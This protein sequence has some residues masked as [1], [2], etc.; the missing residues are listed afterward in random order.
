MTE[1]SRWEDFFS[2]LT[3][4]ELEGVALIRVIECTNGCIQ[5]AFRGENPR[6]LPVEQTRKAMKY[7]MGLMKSLD[8]NIGGK[9]Y[10]F[11]ENS[12]RKLREIRELYV[13]G[14]KQNDDQAMDAFFDASYA[15]VE[16]LGEER[17]RRA[18]CIVKENLQNVFPSHTVDWG[19]NYLMNL[20]ENNES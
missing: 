20:R 12:E 15:C 3:E 7:S 19:F 13:K 1:R 8:F 10:K 18:A 2:S 4:E 17:I 14:F 5:H 9:S 11:S 6:A 16:V